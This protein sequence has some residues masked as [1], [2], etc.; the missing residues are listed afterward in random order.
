MTAEVREQR[1]TAVHRVSYGLMPAGGQAQPAGPAGSRRSGVARPVL[2]G[3]LPPLAES[4]AARPDTVPG[5]EAALAP[6]AA[7]ALVPG[8]EAAG[9]PG[10]WLVSCGKTQLAS[11]AAGSLWR[12]RTVDLLAWVTATSRA[13][14]LSGYLQA[15]TELGLDYQGDAESVAARFVAWLGG[16][17]R[18]WLVVLDDLRDAADLDGLWPAGPAGRLLITAADPV[19]ACGGRRVLAMPVPAFSTREAVSCLLGRLTTDPD[20]RSGAIDLAADLGGQPAAVAQA[21]AVIASSGLP[22]REYRQLFAQRRAQLAAG[23]TRPPSAAAVT[24]TLSADHAGQVAPGAGSWLLLELCAVLDGHGIPGTVFI[25]P[26]VCRYLGEGAAHPPDP[27]HAWTAVRALQ[28]AGL[29]AIGPAGTPPAVWVSPALQAAVRATVP[30]EVVDRAVRA[31]ADALAE[32]WPADQPRCW[33]SAHLRSCVASLRRVAGDGLWAGGRCHRVL[34]MAGQSMN[35]ARLTGPAVTWW[36]ELAAGCDRLLGPGHPD[37][38]VAAGHLAGALLAAGQAAE[39]VSW[40]ER[41]LAGHARVLGPD[42][43]GT[44]DAQVRLG[45]ALVAAGKAGDAAAVLD[46]AA[47][48]SERVHGPSDHGTLA[49]RDEYA[50]ACLA[51]GHAAEAIRAHKRSVAARERLHGPAHPGTLAARAR[52]A[53]AYLA[54]GKV[55]DAASQYRRVLAGRERAL[56]PDHLDTLAARAGLAAACDAAGQMGAALQQ[57]QQACAGYERL[58]GADHPDTL[59]RRAGLAHAYDAAGQLGDAVATL[60]DTITRSEQALSP[61][62]PLTQ[63]LRQ[64]LADITAEMTA[65]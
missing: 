39:A 64:S 18:R 38:L 48:H 50:A 41:V 29:V 51:A 19:T 62:D 6:G 36:R 27:K 11:F 1:E 52:L 35:S 25:T 24:W 5:L 12:S 30:P 15:A 33:L 8:Q 63:S 60:R 21:G 46:E 56:G 53:G 31:A 45:C 58:L 49:A 16:T 14:V 47:G 17:G 2:P 55:K 57:H 40:W 23:G 44:I 59:T 65:G 4:F 42:H 3:P 20:Q 37:T 22:S 9:Y 43:P 54:A 61:G 28:R 26:A 13:S 7:V 32:A 10:D 34:V